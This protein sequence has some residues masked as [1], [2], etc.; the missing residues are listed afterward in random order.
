MR[1]KK[2]LANANLHLEIEVNLSQLGWMLDDT[3]FIRR[4]SRMFFL[5][6]FVLICTQTLVIFI[7]VLA[8][9]P[10]CSHFHDEHVEN[11]VICYR[12]MDATYIQRALFSET[13]SI[14]RLK[15]ISNIIGRTHISL[16]AFILINTQISILLLGSKIAPLSENYVFITIW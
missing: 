4:N 15:K 7:F 3:A 11:L 9:E 2:L 8:D 12:H 16:N 10:R 5:L 14:Y 1:N 13:Q 6:L